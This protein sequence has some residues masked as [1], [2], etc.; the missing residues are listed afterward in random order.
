MNLLKW[1]VPRAYSQKGHGL[2]KIF[3]IGFSK[4]GTTSIEMA[5]EELGYRVCRG[6]WE[7]S[8]TFYLLALYIHRDYD[9]IFRIVEY[10]DAFADGPWGGTD[11]YVELYRRLP[12]SKFILTVRDPDR[13]YDSFEKL[14]TMFD[15]NPETALA[16]YHANGMYGSAYFFKHVFGIET[17]AGNREKI[18]NHYRMYNEQVMEFFSKNSAD[19]MVF[20]ATQG[21]GWEKL[22]GFLNVGAPDKRFPHANRSI[23][24]PYISNKPVPESRSARIRNMARRALSRLR[25]ERRRT[26]YR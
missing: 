2:E 20:D 3:G 17:L 16:A 23:D 21:D 1:V 11:L 25:Q 4:T 6:H 13:W 5:L 8:H 14:V 26:G 19:F 24:N 22:C 18:I 9:E 15:L 10:W 7:R 12:R